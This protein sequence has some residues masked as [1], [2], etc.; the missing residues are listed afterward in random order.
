MSAKRFTIVAINDETDTCSECGKTNL[1]KVAW[2]VDSLG[3]GE[4]VA[5]GVDCAARMLQWTE[6][7]APAR[8]KRAERELVAALVERFTAELGGMVIPHVATIQVTEEL[9]AQRKVWCSHV[10]TGT[11]GPATDRLSV[12]TKLGHTVE[13]RTAEMRRGLES[14]SA[15]SIR[16]AAIFAAVRAEAATKGVTL[17]ETEINTVMG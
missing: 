15:E 12:N 4:A 7:S 11:R 6:K 14:R 10:I 3:D 5:V 8:V 13:G 16:R 9:D 2:I 17:Y 1:K